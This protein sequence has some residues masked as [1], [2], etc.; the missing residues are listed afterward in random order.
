M[1]KLGLYG[2][3]NRTKSL[4]D[5]FKYDEFYKIHA[6]YDLNEKAAEALASQ[7]G[8]T[9]CKSA[10]ELVSFEG[11]DAYLISLAPSTHADALRKI[12]PSGKPIFIEKP[13]SFS[14]A[15]MK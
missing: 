13:V 3:G 6:V 5:T 2:A 7:Y 14:G 1:I 9:V 8:G 10:D 11:V 12:I 4:I 15:E